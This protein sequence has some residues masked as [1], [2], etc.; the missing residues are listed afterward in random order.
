MP[1]EPSI[2]TETARLLHHCGVTRDLS[3]CAGDAG[4][5]HDADTMRPGE[6]RNVHPHATPLR[7]RQA[8]RMRLCSGLSVSHSTTATASTLVCTPATAYKL[9]VPQRTRS[10]VERRDPRRR[11]SVPVTD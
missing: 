10:A 7:S 9:L 4:N 2:S 6:C 3:S 8:A 1:R 11:L 5:S